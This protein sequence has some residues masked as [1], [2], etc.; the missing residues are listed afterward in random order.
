[1]P[2]PTLVCPKPRTTRRFP[3][4]HSPDSTR[5][6]YLFIDVGAVRR[7]KAHDCGH[8]RRRERQERPASRGAAGAAVGASGAKRA[9]CS[10]ERFMKSSAADAPR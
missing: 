8:A 5:A 7:S 6:P 9:G 1:M 3:L 10:V 2:N 4:A